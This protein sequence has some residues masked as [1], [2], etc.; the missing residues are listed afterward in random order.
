VEGVLGGLGFCEWASGCRDIS[1][2]KFHQVACTNSLLDARHE[3]DIAAQDI[4]EGVACALRI[5]SYHLMP[6]PF[7]LGHGH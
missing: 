2:L 6:I 3:N 5:I 4:K 1:S 7:L